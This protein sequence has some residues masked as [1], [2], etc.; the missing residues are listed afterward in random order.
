MARTPNDFI[1]AYEAAL[2]ASV[3]ANPEKYLWTA[4]R[5]PEMAAKMIRNLR[6]GTADLSPTVKAIAKEFGIKPTRRD[7]RAFLNS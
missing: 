2:A 3:K 4:D 5:V 6:D 1:S 7:I